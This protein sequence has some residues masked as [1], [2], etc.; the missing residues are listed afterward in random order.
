MDKNNFVAHVKTDDIYKDIEDLETTF[1]AASNHELEIPLPIEKHKKIIRLLKMKVELREK[2][3][4]K[5]V[6]LRTKI[7]SYLID[8][9]S[10]D[11]ET[12]D[13]KKC[14]IKRKLKFDDYKTCLED[15]QIENKIK[16]LEKHEIVIDSLNEFLKSNKLMLKTQQ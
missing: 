15:V 16:H 7:Y 1:D 11:K 3:M 14:V 6:G 8:D 4:K 12:K 10:E 13:A 5:L 2:I 9:G